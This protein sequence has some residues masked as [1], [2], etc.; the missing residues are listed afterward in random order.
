M[1][2]S[3]NPAKRAQISN[4]SDFKNRNKGTVLTLPSGLSLQ[5][6][7]V[8]LQTFVLRGSVPNPL[9][10]IVSEAL[11]KGQKADVPAMMGMGEGGE[12]DLEMVRDMYDMVSDV[13]I[14][15]VISPKV[16]PVPAEGEI[17][18]DDLL[19]IDEIDPEDQMFIWQWACG[20]T[21]DVAQFRHEARADMATLA[22]SQGVQVPTE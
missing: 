16:H 15:S 12:I 10:D 18:D 11:K 7:R 9:M 2:T 13:V 19:F 4:A 21:S 5:A 6:K 8:D 1:G 14:A 17:R 20:G 22:E 3:G